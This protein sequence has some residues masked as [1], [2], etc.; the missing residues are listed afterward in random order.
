MRTVTIREDSQIDFSMHNV[1]W[2]LWAGRGGAGRG[3]AGRGGAGRGEG[4]G[5]GESGG[6]RF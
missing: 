4:V 5:G 6:Y 2:T 1:K 3:G